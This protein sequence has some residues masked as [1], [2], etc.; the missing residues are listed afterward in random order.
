MGFRI[1]GV[2]QPILC[3]NCGKVLEVSSIESLENRQP[4]P[5]CGST[6]RTLNFSHRIVHVH[7]TMH[8]LES[9][10]AKAID[11]PSLILKTIVEK[12]EKTD[13]GE[14]II[15]VTVPFFQILEAIVQNPELGYQISPRKWEELVAA[16]HE[17]SGMFDEVRL[18]SYSKDRG[19]D[20][21]AIKHGHYSLRI[22]DQV[23]A[24][25]PKYPITADMV[26]SVIGTLQGDSASKAII[27]TTSTFAPRILDDEAIKRYCPYR[28]ELRDYDVLKKIMSDIVAKNNQ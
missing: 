17:N 11:L 25:S 6:K 15:A 14:L 26:K 12:G 21:I 22:I 4:C 20:V 3:S 10:E 8:A 16:I 19:R 27:S 5:D 18:T 28:L 13:E 1:P 2:S 23:K 7:D 24:Y 9:T